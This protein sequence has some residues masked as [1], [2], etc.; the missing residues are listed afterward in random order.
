VVDLQSL[1]LPRHAQHIV[2]IHFPI[3]LFMAGAAFDAA[4]EWRKQAALAAVARYNLAVAAFSTP[5]VVVSGLLAWQFQLEGQRL[6]GELLLHLLFGILSSALICLVWWI[7]FRAGRKPE[8]TLPA[9][10]LP[11]EFFTAVVV[12]V[13]G[14]LGGII[15]GLI[16]R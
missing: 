1:L 13:T 8:R 6:K 5:L 7:H 9:Y 16:P 14:H 11:L 2:L 10:R 4:A 15:S 12:A 3:A